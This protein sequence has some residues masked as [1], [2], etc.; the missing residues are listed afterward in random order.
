MIGDVSI[1]FFWR[2]PLMTWAPFAYLRTRACEAILEG[3]QDAFEQLEQ[4]EEGSTPAK[5]PAAAAEVA[6]KPADERTLFGQAA[7]QPKAPPPLANGTPQ[8][9]A[10][11]IPR[12][13][14]SKAG[15]CEGEQ[16]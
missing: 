16:S 15:K 4:L 12:R 11:T 6:A 9:G 2:K 1:R 13:K 14:H 10:M 3:I 5:E 7:A 8:K